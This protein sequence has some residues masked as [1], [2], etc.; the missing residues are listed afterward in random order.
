ME[1]VQYL[2]RYGSNANLRDS[3]GDTPLLLAC[4]SGQIEVVRLLLE[5]G[6]Y[7]KKFDLSECNKLKSNND[8]IFQVV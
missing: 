7:I 4:R 2:L 8:N 1:I 3:D 5:N 6:K